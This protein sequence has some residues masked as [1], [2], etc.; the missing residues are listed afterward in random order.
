MAKRVQYRRLVL[1]AVVLMAAFAGLGYRLV[2]LQVWRHQELKYKAQQNTQREI[3]LEPRRGDILDAKGNLLATSVFVKTLC[4]DPVLIGNRQAEIARALAPLLQV[5][6]SQL[7]QRLKPQLR[8]NNKGEVVTNRYVVLKRKTPVEL[9]QKIQETMRTLSFGL[10]ETKLPKAEQAF[11]RDLRKQAIFVDSMDDQLRVYPTMSLAAHVLGSVGM[12]ERQ[13]NTNGRACETVGKEGIE[14]SFDSKLRGVRGWRLTETDR[15]KREMV[16]LREQD[17]EP[18]DGLNVVLTIDSVVQNMVETALAEAMEK[19]T[20]AS[21]SGIVV[22]PRTGEVL[23]MATLPNFDPNNPGAATPDARRNRVIADVAEPGSTFKIVVVSG[24]YNDQ[25]VSPTD[26]FDCEHGHFFYAGRPLRDHESYGVLTVENII[27]KSSNIGAAKIGI[28]MGE[29]RLYE[30]IRN[31]GFGTRTGIPLQGEIGGIVHPLKNWSKVSIAQIPMGQGIAV[32]RLQMIMAMCAIANNGW[33]MRPMLVD[34][35]EDQQHRVVAKY[36]PQRVRQ[37][38]SE[39]AAKLMVSALKTVT[40]SDGTAPKAALE[41][42][43]V[44][45]KTGTAQ[46]AEHGFYAPGKY[47]SSFIGFF[48]AD[49]PELCISV[50]MDEPKQ[51]HFGGQTAAPVFKQIAE[52]AANYLNIRPEDGSEVPAPPVPIAP[53]DDRALKSA[54]ART[55]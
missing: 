8:E 12:D 36:A 41:H 55:P 46:K 54:A 20:P 35:L 25:L 53:L 49:N 29:R 21:I 31:F 23:A 3:F 40:S 47:F 37:V 38:I 33:L 24:A 26:T 6:E 10:E 4:A 5:P 27:T 17:V 14:L 28:K 51:G 42:Y 48:P 19:H 2:D 44:A 43:C 50:M 45:G 1:M 32:T 11:Y 7:A 34:R 9:W 52:R 30:Y 13:T 39:P 15:H 18:R 16:N 22:R